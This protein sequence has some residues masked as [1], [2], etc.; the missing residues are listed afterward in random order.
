MP[1][2]VVGLGESI[3]EYAD[4]AEEFARLA[5]WAGVLSVFIVA[6][7]LTGVLVVTGLRR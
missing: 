1:V 5:L 4:K 3:Y 7:L 2:V 6:A